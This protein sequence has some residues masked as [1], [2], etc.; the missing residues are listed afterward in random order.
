M[1]T[2]PSERLTMPPGGSAEPGW[3][4]KGI[5]EVVK[6]PDRVASLFD[7]VIVLD[8]DHAFHIDSIRNLF[9]R[10]RKH[11]LALSPAK[12]KFSVIDAIRSPAAP[13]SR[14]TSREPPQPRGRLRYFMHRTHP[15]TPLVYHVPHLLRPQSAREHRQDRRIQLAS[16]SLA[17]I[18]S[19]LNLFN[20]AKID[21]SAGFL[22][23]LP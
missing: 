4:V 10:L 12:D 21:G 2:R 22:S 15:R 7:I 1:P 13:P 6:K 8:P 19:H 9:E 18:P 20:T 11:N 23:R 16:L 17:E 3:V 5:S 14:T